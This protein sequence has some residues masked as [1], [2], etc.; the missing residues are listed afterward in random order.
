MIIL[1]DSRIYL[2]IPPAGSFSFEGLMIFPE[3]FRPH[4]SRYRLSPTL[5]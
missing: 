2:E 5:S 3:K 1:H 4:A